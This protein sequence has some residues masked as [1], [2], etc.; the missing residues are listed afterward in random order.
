MNSISIVPNYFFQGIGKPKIPTIINLIEL[1]FYIIAML[2]SIDKLGINGAALTYMLAA[3]LDALIMYIMV[4]K[5][6]SIKLWSM[7]IPI[8]ILFMLISFIIPFLFLAFY[9]KIVFAFI[10]ISVFIPVVWNYLLSSEEKV[11]LV[12]KIKLIFSNS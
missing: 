7:R 4:Y 2:I 11:F 5:I 6:T 8:L 3:S 9:L 12:S 1:P 10:V